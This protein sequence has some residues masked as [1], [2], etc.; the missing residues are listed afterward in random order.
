MTPALKKVSMSD[1]RISL[2]FE[3]GAIAAQSTAAAPAATSSAKG[4]PGREAAQTRLVGERV[5]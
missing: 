2:E 5:I 1:N 3:G 4:D